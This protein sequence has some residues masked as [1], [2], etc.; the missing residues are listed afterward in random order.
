MNVA[1]PFQYLLIVIQI[2]LNSKS[3]ESQDV[4]KVEQS[5]KVYFKYNWTDM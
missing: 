2:F 3:G 1:I 5:I 4:I